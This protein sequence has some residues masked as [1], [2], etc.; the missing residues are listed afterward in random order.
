[1]LCMKISVLFLMLV[2][3]SGISLI[4]MNQAFALFCTS[5]VAGTWNDPSTWDNCGVGGIPDNTGDSADIQT[6]GDVQLNNDFVIGSLTVQEGGSLSLNAKLTADDLFIT[7]TSDLFI[8][9]VGKLI[10]TTNEG[11][12]NFGLITNHGLLQT[13]AGFGFSNDGTYQS[14]A[15]SILVPICGSSCL[16]NP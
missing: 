11:G 13:L 10:I 2:I 5:S 4:G 15:A 14:S 3:I 1:M 16:P 9:C 12:Q 7:S 8:N 6:N